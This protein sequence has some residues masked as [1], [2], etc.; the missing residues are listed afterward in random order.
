[1]KKII[2][3][4][5]SVLIAYSMI[6]AIPAQAE[7]LTPEI[8][9]TETWYESYYIDEDFETEYPYLKCDVNIYNN[10]VVEFTMLHDYE[11]SDFDIFSSIVYTKRF[12]AVRPKSEI[13]TIYNTYEYVEDFDI[14][15]TNE[16]YESTTG[17]QSVTNNRLV[18]ARPFHENEIWYPDT[19]YTC[20]TDD[21]INV[22]ESSKNTIKLEDGQDLEQY[23]YNKYLAKHPEMEGNFSTDFI[24]DECYKLFTE[25]SGFTLN[26]D[27]KKVARWWDLG[28]KY[29]VSIFSGSIGLFNNGYI[30]LKYKFIPNQRITEPM[31]FNVYGHNITVTP[32]MIL[33]KSGKQISTENESSF[34]ESCKQTIANLLEENNCLK[35]ENSILMEKTG[36]LER[37]LTTYKNNPNPDYNGDGLVTIADAVW[38]IK[39]ISEC[40]GLT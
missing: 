30:C 38:L 21:F 22:Y 28:P 27:I 13:D 6:S 4:V 2:S 34:I 35:K 15:V 9:K 8:I 17:K 29:L 20:D 40:E 7:V 36:T 11:W 18:F 39:Y 19:V 1:M 5:S 26:S 32:D 10:G 23:L 33:N 25:K 37:L 3:F 16:E 14:Y 24:K 12:G 31:S